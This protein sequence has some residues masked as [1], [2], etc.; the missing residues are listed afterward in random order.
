MRYLE[1]L[2]EN[3]LLWASLA[4]I[5][6]LIGYIYT[7]LVYLTD[8]NAVGSPW[9]GF[10]IG[11][12][13]SSLSSGF[14]LAYVSSPDSAFRKFAFLPSM[15][16]R[17]LVHLGII[18]FSLMFCQLIYLGLT[19]HN[20]LLTGGSFQDALTDILFSFFVV[21]M[22]VFLMQ[23]RL[24]IGGRQLRNLIIGQ[25]HNPIVEDRVFLFLD[26]AGS[27]EAAQRLGD[28]GFHKYLNHLFVLF[29]RAIT[30]F[31]GEVHSYVG[32]AIIAVWPLEA[33]PEKNK[34][35]I[36]ALAEIQK[37]CFENSENVE[38]R[39]GVLPRI[40]MAVHGGSVVV[41][42]T[43]NSKRQI[44][45]LGNTVNVTARIEAKAKELG[46]SCLAS[47]DFLKNCNLPDAVFTR[48]EG[49]HRLKGLD[50]A[51]ALS[52]IHFGDNL[53]VQEVTKNVSA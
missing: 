21:G 14:E 29:D 48:E 22:I 27:T 12:L 38:S 53:A 35:I 25:Y 8:E 11:F 34:R 20:L 10:G 50:G 32:D 43:G 24:F 49:E 16:A 44:T 40:R 46:T 52:S 15:F 28:V 5:G 6:G 7:S 4:F 33:N 18:V 13:L 23:M 31:G 26:V 17:T 19:G 47:S 2:K 9:L 45:Y 37:L 41:G 3:F 30:K 36:H 51:I 42:E 1:N 39:F